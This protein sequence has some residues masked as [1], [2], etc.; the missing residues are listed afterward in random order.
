MSVFVHCMVNTGLGLCYWKKY[1]L[2]LVR[3]SS[4][5]EKPI[6]LGDGS[7]YTTPYILLL[8][9]PSG[10]GA[11]RTGTVVLSYLLHRQQTS[12]TFCHM[13]VQKSHTNGHTAKISFT[14][15]TQIRKNEFFR[16]AQQHANPEKWPAYNMYLLLV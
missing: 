15:I 10:S 5:R 4:C 9:Q 12:G 16:R 14:Q 13:S 2:L 7:F 11:C 6:H 1:N 3:I 8:Q